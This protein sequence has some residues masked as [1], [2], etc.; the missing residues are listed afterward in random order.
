MNTRDSYRFAMDLE[1]GAAI[2]AESVTLP[3]DLGSPLLRKPDVFPQGRADWQ[4]VSG[5]AATNSLG[6]SVEIIVYRKQSIGFELTKNTPQ[7]L[8]DSI[9]GVKEV[10]AIHI[11]F[12]AAQLP[13]GAQEKVIPEDAILSVG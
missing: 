3:D 13:I 5:Q 1:S 9:Y 6:R 10:P 12:P 8:L 2:A 4:D 11:E 7:L